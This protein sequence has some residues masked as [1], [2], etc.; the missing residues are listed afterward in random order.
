MQTKKEILSA[1]GENYTLKDKKLY[2]FMNKWL[3]PIIDKKESIN[4]KINWQELEKTLDPQRQKEAFASISPLMRDLV[5][6]VGTKIR[7]HNGYIYIP[8][9][10][11]KLE[12]TL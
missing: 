12:K 9:L 3:Q 4:S 1:L 5:D 8:N 11:E 7:E 10:R 6:A 2:I